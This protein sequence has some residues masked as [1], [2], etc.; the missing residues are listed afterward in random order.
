MKHF[1]HRRNEIQTP[2]IDITVD[3]QRN[4]RRWLHRKTASLSVSAK[5]DSPCNIGIYNVD[6]HI[7]ETIVN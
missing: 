4:H 6:L 1:R 7:L 3:D 2:A 5:E